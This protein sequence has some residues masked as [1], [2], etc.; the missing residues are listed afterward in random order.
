MRSSIIGEFGIQR[1]RSYWL[2][3]FLDRSGFGWMCSLLFLV[4]LSMTVQLN[5]QLEVDGPIHL[6][7]VEGFVFNSAGKP[8]VDAEVRLVRDENVAKTTRTDSTGAF[9]FDHAAGKFMF[10]VERTQEAPAA[11]EVIV[12]DELVT[13][14]ERKRLYVVV[15]PG[16]CTDECSSVFTS[17][18]EYEQLIRRN[19]ERRH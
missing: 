12:T 17:K 1:Q 10:R 14:V 7:H 3:C 13:R 9:R 11:R 4:M 8:V 19:N 6:S 16:A 18:K 15:G 5:A 2:R